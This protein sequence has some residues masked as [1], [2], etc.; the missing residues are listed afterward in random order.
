[1]NIEDIIPGCW[2]SKVWVSRLVNRLRGRHEI[3]TVRVVTS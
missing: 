1:M 2:A 3:L